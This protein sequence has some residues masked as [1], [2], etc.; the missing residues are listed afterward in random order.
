MKTMTQ[1]PGSI[2]Q[3]LL[4]NI[5]NGHDQTCLRLPREEEGRTGITCGPFETPSQAPPLHQTLRTSFQLM[6]VES[7]VGFAK[8]IMPS[9]LL[10]ITLY[11][12]HRAKKPVLY[13]VSQVSLCVEHCISVSILHYLLLLGRKRHFNVEPLD[14]HIKKKVG[15]CVTFHL[16]YPH[17]FQLST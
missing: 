14:S 15:R 4:L 11:L 2:G 12:D 13:K 1:Q 5:P 7:F 17:L 3:F 10:M 9:P 16:R 8:P 6:I